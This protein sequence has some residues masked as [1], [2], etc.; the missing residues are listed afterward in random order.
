MDFTKLINQ[1]N[2]I[3]PFVQHKPTHKLLLLLSILNRFSEIIPQK[4]KQKKNERKSLSFFFC[5]GCF[6]QHCTFIFFSFFSFLFFLLRKCNCKPGPSIESEINPMDSK[7]PLFYFQ[8]WGIEKK[9]DALYPPTCS[10]WKRKN[11]SQKKK[12]NLTSNR[13]TYA[14]FGDTLTLLKRKTIIITTSFGISYSLSL[15]L[16]LSLSAFLCVSK[17]FETIKIK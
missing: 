15:S 13:K 14:F 4:W 9:I 10:I 7:V 1:V 17:N 6:C 3:Y 2:I 12:W 11:N 5:F 8:D 16:S